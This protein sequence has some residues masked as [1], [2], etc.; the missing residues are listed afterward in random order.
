M[1]FSANFIN[2]SSLIWKQNWK[3]R[4]NLHKYRLE[5]TEKTSEFAFLIHFHCLSERIVSTVVIIKLFKK[6]TACF[7]F[8]ILH[9]KYKLQ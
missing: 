2:C 3:D 4:N 8:C 1:F 7:A 5:V 9:V 6:G